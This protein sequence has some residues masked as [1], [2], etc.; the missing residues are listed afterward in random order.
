MKEWEPSI[1]D[2]LVATSSSEAL[3]GH[4]DLVN[5]RWQLLAAFTNEKVSPTILSPP[6]KKLKSELYRKEGD[7]DEGSLKQYKKKLNA[8]L[9][10]LS[11]ASERLDA[12][13]REE[14]G[15]LTFRARFVS[16]LQL[17]LFHDILT[18][19]KS[20]KLLNIKQVES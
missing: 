4:R 20:S 18:K 7:L 16:L 2:Q 5:H 12:V 15:D 19:L 8:Y 3:S 9:Q 11:N 13:Q 10:G 14:V 17:K 1:Q 6:S